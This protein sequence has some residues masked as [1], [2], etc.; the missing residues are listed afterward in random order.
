M[1]IL[2]TKQ[3]EYIRVHAG[4]TH[5]SDVQVLGRLH[6]SLV[7]DETI[8][9]G[10]IQNVGITHRPGKLLFS[11]I[12]QGLELSGYAGISQGSSIF[13]DR[14]G[15][16]TG[17]IPGS[18]I[19]IMQGGS[20]LSS[21]SGINQERFAD[22]DKVGI[23]H[24][25]PALTHAGIAH[26]VP[27]GKMAFSALLQ[28]PSE[29]GIEKRVSVSLL[30]RIQYR[31]FVG[32]T[33]QLPEE[34]REFCGT[35]HGYA[36]DVES[37]QFVSVI[38]TAEQKLFVGI[39]HQ[40]PTEKIGFGRLHNSV[41]EKVVSK[42]FGITQGGET[43]EKTVFAGITHRSNESFE[44]H[45][46]DP[47]SYQ[48]TGNASLVTPH[49][50]YLDGIEISA[51]H[52]EFRISYNRGESHG[53]IEIEGIDKEIF[54]MADPEKQLE[55]QVDIGTRSRK[56]FLESITGDERKC[57]LWGRSLSGLDDLETAIETD[58]VIEQGQ[59]AQEI[60]GSVL[61]NPLIFNID[62]FTLPTGWQ[63]SGKPLDIVRRI[64]QIV[65]AR[66]YPVDGAGI[67]IEKMFPVRP[68]DAQST[69]PVIEYEDTTIF[70]GDSGSTKKGK[71]YDSVEIFGSASAVELPQLEVEPL[72]NNANR[73]IGTPSHIRVWPKNGSEIGLLDGFVTSGDIT[74]VGSITTEH[75][76]TIN[77]TKTV[78][79]VNYPI[80]QIKNV[81]WYDLNGGNIEFETGGTELS[82]SKQYAI[83]DITYE[84]TYHRYLLKNH[85]V[86]NMIA[87]VYINASEDA[88]AIIAIDENNPAPAITDPGII[89]LSVMVRRGTAFLDTGY[90]RLVHTFESLYQDDLDIGVI[91]GIND[92]RMG[93]RGNYYVR[94]YD[95]L[96]KGPKLS[97]ALEVEQCLIS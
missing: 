46:S 12:L 55:I 38:Q 34:K 24:G 85:S 77:F 22:C 25:L 86:M 78:G 26:E 81:A 32:I 42:H 21:L 3:P 57:T 7:S 66:I 70:Y 74:H 89:D 50:I 30:N 1:L 19:G 63:V 31:Q 68:V 67:R 20:V 40:I 43:G 37:R 47:G 29:F 51:M 35:T 73:Y 13:R 16:T 48:I 2:F 53:Y 9:D 64:C 88:A 84:T 45:D 72:P 96:S 59:T 5:N 52:T 75:T 61:T 92:A 49:E 44:T 23:S 36:Y 56:F 6:N 97:Q 27:A 33:N 95:I 14:S 94:K 11:R 62:N 91:I 65:G 71:R 90:G 8:I 79:S 15:I 69:L 58:I 87:G 83:A 41:I 93:N 76:Q 82:I 39:T 54:D 60:I 28:G 18:Q 10:Q 4:I 17:Y 80:K